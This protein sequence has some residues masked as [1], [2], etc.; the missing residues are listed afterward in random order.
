MEK[1]TVIGAFVFLPFALETTI[2]SNILLP[3]PA[4][5]ETG[6]A[7]FASSG[8]VAGC[9]SG[10]C[11]QTFATPVIPGDDKRCGDT[12]TGVRSYHNSDDQGK[13]KGTKHLAA[14]QEEDEDRQECQSA[15][16]NGSRER[17]IN[18]F[19]DDVGERFFPDA[20]VILGGAVDD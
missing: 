14:H 11:R 15:G 8:L 6:L 13:G 20:A 19:V 17:L 3:P 5:R 2:S 1:K 12:K 7:A 4:G 9:G 18:G 10:A 16:K